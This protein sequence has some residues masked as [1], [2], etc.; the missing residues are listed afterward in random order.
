[1]PDS[2]D[3]EVVRAVVFSDLEGFTAFT[4]ERGDAEASALLRDHYDS[5]ET[6]TRSRGGQVIK[7]IGDGHMLVF[8]SAE[9]AVM[10]SLDLVE[11][12]PGPLR[13]RSGSHLGSVI[14]ADGDYFGASRISHPASPTSPRAVPHSSPRPFGSRSPIYPVS[15]S[16]NPRRIDSR[17]SQ[18]PWGCASSRVAEDRHRSGR[19]LRLLA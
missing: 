10:A 19:R 1:M 7:K 4:G 18:N 8:P 2:S 3:A 5:V 13:L 17:G 14:E 9:S 15:S 16:R 6:L 12:A 11:A